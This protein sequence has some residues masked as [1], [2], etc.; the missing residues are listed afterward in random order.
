MCSHHLVTAIAHNIVCGGVLI[1]HLPAQLGSCL[2]AHASLLCVAASIQS[3]LP[4]SHK[5]YGLGV[6]AVFVRTHVGLLSP[7]VKRHPVLFV[8]LFLFVEA[9]CVVLGVLWC[10]GVSACRTLCHMASVRP[11]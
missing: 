11:L 9:C 2:A 5:Q 6:P 3:V 10:P 8:A 4:G 7:V 1:G